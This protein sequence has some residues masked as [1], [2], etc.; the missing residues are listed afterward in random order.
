MLT[1]LAEREC[2]QP[3]HRRTTNPANEKE[4]PQ[5]TT[6]QSHGRH[7][8]RTKRTVSRPSTD[9]RAAYVSASHIAVP[10]VQCGSVGYL[11]MDMEA[12]RS[13][14]RTAD[15]HV[16]G[17]DNEASVTTWVQDSAGKGTMM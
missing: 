17:Q 11:R 6:P 16:S 2:L 1:G 13:G 3:V 12:Y 15:D 10:V 14:L 5:L 4:E 7:P 8:G 9:D